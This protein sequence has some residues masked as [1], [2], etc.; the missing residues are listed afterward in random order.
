MIEGMDSLIRKHRF[1]AGLDEETIR[2]LAGCARNVRFDPG[3]YLFHSGEHAREFYLIRQ[4]RVALELPVPGRTSLTVQT[5]GED[6]LV[7]VAWLVAPHRWT[8]DARAVDLVRAVGMDAE[9][10][11][12]KCDADPRVGYEMMQRFV[13]LLVERLQATSLQVLDVYGPAAR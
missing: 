2:L 7:G 4:G 6:D 12:R 13:P 5:M 9:C 8:H 3:Q 11:R 1:F 10:L